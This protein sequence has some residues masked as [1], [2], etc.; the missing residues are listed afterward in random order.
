MLKKKD[1]SK[2]RDQLVTDIF[3]QFCYLIFLDLILYRKLNYSQKLKL[4]RSGD[5]YIR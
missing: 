1:P 3:D 4:F 2:S 5:Y